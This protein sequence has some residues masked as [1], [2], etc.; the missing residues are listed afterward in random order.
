MKTLAVGVAIGLI[1]LSLY[2][3]FH[4]FLLE[5]VF[6]FGFLP[7]FLIYTGLLGLGYAAY[8]TV[9]FVK[10]LI[11]TR[12]TRPWTEPRLV[13]FAEVFI[14]AFFFPLLFTIPIA[15]S[16]NQL[17]DFSDPKIITVQVEDHQITTKSILQQRSCLVKFSIS[18]STPDLMDSDFRFRPQK[19]ECVDLKNQKKLDLVVKSGF[20]GTTWLQSIRQ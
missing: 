11:V 8:R 18:N 4:N 3:Y 16:L 20:L 15:N 7:H 12:Y 5:E 6:F 10:N 14:F 19:T 17:L 2:P 1:M 13:L 9:P